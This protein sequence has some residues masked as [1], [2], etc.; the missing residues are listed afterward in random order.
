MYSRFFQFVVGSIYA[1]GMISCGN[2][3]TPKPNQDNFSTINDGCNINAVISGKNWKSHCHTLHANHIANQ[4]IIGYDCNDTNNIVKGFMI[5]LQDF[6]GKGIY[7]FSDTTDGKITLVNAQFQSYILTYQL[8]D[9]LKITKY[10]PN[11]LKAKFQLRLVN[12]NDR[13]DTLYISSGNISIHEEKGNCTI[14]RML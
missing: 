12:A 8:N 7:T 5:S 9:T 2:A 13:S 11:Q 6:D 14:N 1:I 10:S 4:L 3:S